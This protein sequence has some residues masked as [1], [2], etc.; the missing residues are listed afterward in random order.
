MNDPITEGREL[1][2][3][4]MAGA[5]S[6]AEFVRME[7]LMAAHPVLQAEWKVQQEMDIVL[8]TATTTMPAVSNKTIAF[9]DSSN[10]KPTLAWRWLAA[11]A[12]IAL[13][14]G[15][16]WQNQHS[17]ATVVVQRPEADS[18]APLLV[19]ENRDDTQKYDVWILP[20]GADQAT[21]PA[22]FKKENVRSPLPMADLK[23]TDPAG[24]KS[25]L[26]AGGKYALLV[27]LASTNRMAGTM[28]P[29][30]VAPDARPLPATPADAFVQ[31]QELLN[32]KDPGGAK[33]FLERLPSEWR[34]LPEIRNQETR[35]VQP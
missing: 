4:A 30:S 24:R 21:T 33:R 34:G 6:P 3:R 31:L 28:V 8:A 10:P 14:A 29:F 13:L 11:A 23:P 2:A 32:N 35:L 19:W 16:W 12:A 5:L 20:D 1:I 25:S 17:A 18:T 26:Q 27:C 15:V 7:D 9:P 22:L